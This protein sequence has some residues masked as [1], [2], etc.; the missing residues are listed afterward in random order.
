MANSPAKLERFFDGQPSQKMAT[1]IPG[2]GPKNG[3]YM[4]NNYNI[5]QA[6]QVLGY[7]W[8]VGKDEIKFKGWLK[9]C[10]LNNSEQE[11]ECYKCISKWSRNLGF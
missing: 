3:E 9:M 4:K 6:S 10:G 8:G 1:D 7:F 5:V 11:E 2:I